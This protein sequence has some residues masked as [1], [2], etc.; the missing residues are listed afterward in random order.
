MNRMIHSLRLLMLLICSLLMLNTVNA[1]QEKPNILMICI[2]DL[3]DWTGFLGG[4][5]QALT[6]NMD[7]LA[8]RGVNF[9]NAH[10]PAPGC[11]PSR[12]A[13]LFGIEPHN[14]GLYPFYRI[15]N[16]APGILESYTPLPKL[17]RFNGYTTCGISKVWHNPDSSY[18]KNEQWDEYRFY[19]DNEMNLLREKGYWPNPMKTA[20]QNVPASNPITDFDDYKSAMHAV[21]FLGREHDK[22]FLLAVGFIFPHTPLNAPLENWER[23][24]EPI[25]LLPI[26]AND[27]SDIPLAGQS[28]VQVTL[29]AQ[30]RRDDAW[31]DIYRAYLACTNFTDD[32]VGR[33][34]DALAASGYMDNTIVILWSDHG[35]QMGAKRSLSKFTLWNESTRVPFIIW[36]ARSQ[37]GN[38]QTYDE[39]VGLIDIYKTICELADLPTPS[40]VDG[41]SLVPWL[42]NPGLARERPAMTTWGRGNYS[43]RFKDWRYTRYFDGSE[44]LYAED[45]DFNEWTNLADR[46]RYSALKQELAK[47][48][49][50]FEAP[51]VATGIDYYE[52][53]DADAPERKILT[54]KEAVRKYNEEKLLPPLG[55]DYAE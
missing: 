13:I 18:R 32:N 40:Y 34:L 50:G 14:S 41:G 19:H 21:D 54:F 31:E 8:S 35:F 17:L 9:T 26:L 46:P 15:N 11:S 33:V 16:V 45:C 27:L 22:P 39:P 55:I 48:L 44:E 5:P 53:A 1:Q 2:D 51:Q 52:V 43:L 30:L 38:G 29:E 49:P 24:S 12:N 47:W 10:C 23:F 4:H 28:N 42:E 7:E 25:E 20:L 36:D 6:P 3:N 37:D